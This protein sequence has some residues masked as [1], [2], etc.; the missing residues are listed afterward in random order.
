VLSSMPWDGFAGGQWVPQTW[1]PENNKRYMLYQLHIQV[2]VSNKHDIYHVWM[3]YAMY[4]PCIYYV[5]T[6]QV[7]IYQLYTRNKF[8]IYHMV[9]TMYLHIIFIWYT[10]HVQSI[11]LVYTEYLHSIYQAYQV[12]TKYILSTSKQKAWWHWMTLR[13]VWILVVLS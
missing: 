3:E 8:G 10:I 6:A 9:Y 1:N 13:S 11:N 7:V 2:Y 5:Y 12:Y 4:L